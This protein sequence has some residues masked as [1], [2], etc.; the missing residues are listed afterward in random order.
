[1]SSVESVRE[2]YRESFRPNDPE[3]SVAQVLDFIDY[4]LM[5]YSHGEDALYPYGFH[6]I[7]ICEGI[8]AR[9][10]YRP[11]LDW[12]GDSVDRE[13]V[14]DMILESREMEAA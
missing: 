5:F 11:S 4:F 6:F 12:D 1:M 3:L 10:K 14:R 9:M 2:F 7:E 8:I 13:L